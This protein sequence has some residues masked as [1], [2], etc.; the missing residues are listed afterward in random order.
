MKFLAAS[1]NCKYIF[2]WISIEEFVEFIKILGVVEEKL[3][4]P[5]QYALAN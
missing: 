4:G 2:S 3:F 5:L 1:H